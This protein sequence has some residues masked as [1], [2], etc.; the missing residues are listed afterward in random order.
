M[1]SR[2]ISPILQACENSSRTTDFTLPGMLPTCLL[3]LVLSHSL[4]NSHLCVTV[5]LTPK[6]VRRPIYAW[7]TARCSF[8]QA[9]FSML[10]VVLPSACAWQPSRSLSSLS[11]RDLSR[12]IDTKTARI[13]EQ[14]H[15]RPGT[16]ARLFKL[17]QVCTVLLPSPQARLRVPS[18]CR[19]VEARGAAWMMRCRKSTTRCTLP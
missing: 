13:V 5:S 11:S 10:T 3:S 16:T 12:L 6:Y 8:V 15:R 7:N 14:V 18:T 19:S 1:C 17:L 4:P 9:L 2:G